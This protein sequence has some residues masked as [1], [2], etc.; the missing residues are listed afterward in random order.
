MVVSKNVAGGVRDDQLTLDGEA[1]RPSCPGV[2]G[3]RGQAVPVATWSSA[4]LSRLPFLEHA[5]H[6]ARP[7]RDHVDHPE[8]L[9]LWRLAGVD[10]GLPLPTVSGIQAQGLPL[11]SVGLGMGLLDP[12]LGALGVSFS[13][14]GSWLC[15]WPVLGESALQCP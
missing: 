10:S 2:G 13:G 15:G 11:L 5:L 14:L 4:P 3:G 7:P 1:W 9:W 8:A 6:P 12:V